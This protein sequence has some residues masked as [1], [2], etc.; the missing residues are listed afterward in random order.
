[1]PDN[2]FFATEVKTVSNKEFKQTEMENYTRS[3]FF[4]GVLLQPLTQCPIDV[5]SLESKTYKVTAFSISV[6]YCLTLKKLLVYV[7]SYSD[8]VE[9]YVLWKV[10]VIYLLVM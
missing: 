8:Q 4:V 9:H 10:K 1:M 7:V 6:I 5:T 3:V 2:G